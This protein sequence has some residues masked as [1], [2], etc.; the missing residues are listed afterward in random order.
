MASILVF[1]EDH[2]IFN[3]LGYVL[4]T[5]GHK[6]RILSGSR[7]NLS[8]AK[9][10]TPDLVMIDSEHESATVNIGRAI[11]SYAPWNHVR[12]MVFTR[13]PLNKISR[14]LIEVADC[15]VSRPIKVKEVLRN[16]TKLAIQKQ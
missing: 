13:R 15:K 14:A 7:A 4:Q 10:L 11:R 8:R 6:V 16:V 9:C 5:Q 1:T 12:I 2:E 3:M